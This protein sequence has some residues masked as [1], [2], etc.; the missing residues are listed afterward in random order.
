MVVVQEQ[1]QTTHLGTRIDKQAQ[2]LGRRRSGDTPDLLALLGRV[3]FA[4]EGVLHQSGVVLD[5]SGAKVVL[6]YRHPGCVLAGQQGLYEHVGG[7]AGDRHEQDAVGGRWIR[8]R[9]C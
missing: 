1:R 9:R 5:D 8:S 3:S 6:G 2:R 7:G 4:V